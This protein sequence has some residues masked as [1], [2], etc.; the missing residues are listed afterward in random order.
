MAGEIPGF[1]WSLPAAADYS[2]TGKNKFVKITNNSGSAEATLT[3]GGTDAVAGVCQ[4]NPRSGE[5]AS[6][7]SSG[8][9]FV[10]VNG[11]STN[12]A[13]GDLVSPSATAGVGV[14]SAT[15]GHTVFGVALAAATTD[16]AVIPVFATGG[17]KAIV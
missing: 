2:S 7:V 14:K 5:A 4:N 16:G 13:V 11:A 3:S 6:I 15:A 8:V 10:T 9:V 1:S 17:T 12:I